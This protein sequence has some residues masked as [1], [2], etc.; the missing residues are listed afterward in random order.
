[1]NNPALPVSDPDG[2]VLPFPADD[3]NALLR[4]FSPEALFPFHVM[5]G[6]VL[7]PS[8]GAVFFLMDGVVEVSHAHSRRVIDVIDRVFPVGIIESCYACDVMYYKAKSSCL[9]YRVDNVVWHEKIKTMGLSFSVCVVISYAFFFMTKHA[10]DRVA[11]TH[12]RRVRQLVY[13]Y[14]SQ[15]AFLSPLRE[16]LSE[17]ILSRVTIS[18]SQVMRILSELRKGDYIHIE[19]GCLM[20]I[21]RKLPLDF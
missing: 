11:K 13:Q 19:R 6:D 10:G 16:S 5:E 21:N 4:C 20:S 1:M 9:V 3:I 2:M 18:R 17:F 8:E 15:K 14:D 12:Y 7:S